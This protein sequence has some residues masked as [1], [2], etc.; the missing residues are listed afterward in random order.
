[1]I[2]ANHL[3]WT[4]LLVGNTTPQ[5]V[6]PL[7]SWMWSKVVYGIVLS[8]LKSKVS[9]HIMTYLIYLSVC[10]SIYL[11]RGFLTLITIFLSCIFQPKPNF[12]VPHICGAAKGGAQ[13]ELRPA[14][15]Y[16]SQKSTIASRGRDP[17]SR[18]NQTEKH[19]YIINYI[20][21]LQRKWISKSKHL[22]NWIR[23]G[24]NQHD[25][26]EA[27]TS[28]SFYYVLAPR[29]SMYLIHAWLPLQRKT[30]TSTSNPESPPVSMAPSSN[31]AAPG[32]SLA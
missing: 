25:N 2:S 18:R 7:G 32:K 12:L 1:M 24:M 28:K 16:A 3:Q 15:Q 20:Q 8:A 27:L 31:L 4:L 13:S 22:R 23:N 6:L 9:S 17:T 26:I 5:Q 14:S 10:L 29:W 19:L 21:R 11:S 30:C